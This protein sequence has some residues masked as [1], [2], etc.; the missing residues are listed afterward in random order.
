MPN[1]R[2]PPDMVVRSAGVWDS[3]APFHNFLFS[4]RRLNRCYA[5]A[6]LSATKLQRDAAALNGSPVRG[7]INP[8]KGQTNRSVDPRELAAWKSYKRALGRDRST[9]DY[10]SPTADDLLEDS[11]EVIGEMRQGTVTGMVALFEG[12]LQNWTLNVL[13]DKLERGETWSNEERYLACKL[14]PVHSTEPDPS[15]AFILR[16]LPELQILLKATPATFK[17]FKTGQPLM[18]P[19]S[20]LLS[21]FSVIRFWI[22]V[23]NQLVHRQGW[24]SVAFAK[25]H[26]PTWEAIFSGWSHI[27]PL[28]P[29]RALLIHHEVANACSLHV[30]RAALR[31]SDELELRSK[32]RRG[33]PWSPLPRPEQQSNYTDVPNP[34]RLLVDGDHEM[35]LRW[36]SDG[37]FRNAYTDGNLP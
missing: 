28:K 30:Y 36:A 16:C 27:Q 20:T 6:V 7:L 35:S 4:Y 23:R 10:R 37:V 8:R 14:S 12:F 21:S 2:M 22:H 32:G 34:N 13:L 29:G 33:Q 26:A 9:G 24:V 19:V 5:L 15:A 3:R 11:D 31:L 17:D 18:S 25:K 1:L